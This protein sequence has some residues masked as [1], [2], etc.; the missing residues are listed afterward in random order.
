MVN[1]SLLQRVQLRACRQIGQTFN[2]RGLAFVVHDRQ[3][4]AG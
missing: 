4:Q 2:G 3:R 1:E